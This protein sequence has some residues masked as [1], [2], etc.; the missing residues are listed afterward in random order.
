MKNLIKHKEG[1]PSFVT[2]I[3][4]RISNNLNFIALFQGPTGIGKSWSALKIAYDLDKEFE[5]SQVAFDFR[6]VMQIINAV[7]FKEKKLKVIIFDEAQCDLSNREWQSL[8]NKLMNYLLST[9]RHQNIILLFTSPYSDFMDSHSRKLLHCIFDCRG[10]DK[11]KKANLIRPKLQQY[12]PKMKKFYEHGLYVIHDNGVDKLNNWW[13]GRPP[14]HLIV[15]Y[16]KKKEAFTDKLNNDI[17][18]QLSKDDHKDD[19][20]KLTDIQEEI[21]ITLA[22]HEGNAKRTAEALKIK[23]DM[24]YFHRRQAEK[25]NYSW[26]E[27]I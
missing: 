23:L 1:E 12:N 21:L 5:V 6:G 14:E 26:K 7:W 17:L 20:K 9:F 13:V 15:P 27:F 2:W 18:A 10:T 4:K 3:K 8:T 19:R 24:V 11:K 25:K 16:E 22:Q